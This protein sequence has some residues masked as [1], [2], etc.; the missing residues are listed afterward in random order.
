MLFILPP[1][2]SSGTYSRE[3]SRALGG[4]V[5]AV[6]GRYDKHIVLSEQRKDPGELSVEPV[7]RV[8]ISFYIV[9]VPYSISKST[10]LTKHRPLKS[11]FSSSFSLDIPSSLPDVG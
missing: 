5:A 6:V 3:W 4:G 7:Q 8:R 1:K 2:T 11:F 10:R 9:P